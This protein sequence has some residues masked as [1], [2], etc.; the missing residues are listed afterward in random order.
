[1]VS[2]W[3][4]IELIPV[5]FLELIFKFRFSLAQYYHVW[6]STQKLTCSYLFFHLAWDEIIEEE[7]F[8]FQMLWRC[9]RRQKRKKDFGIQTFFVNEDNNWEL[10]IEN[11]RPYFFEKHP[12]NSRF[13]TV[14]YLGKSVQN[15][16]SFLGIVQKVVL[17]SLKV[18]HNFIL[19]TP[20]NSTSFLIGPCK[21]H[22]LFLWYLWKLPVLT[23]SSLSQS[24]YVL[25]K[26]T[27]ALKHMSSKNSAIITKI[28]LIL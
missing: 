15:K 27:I 13:I 24:E 17:F 9:C 8:L 2:I 14:Y 26:F 5:N 19:N 11:W 21:F 3:F 16:A 12:G 1:M 4:L 22:E 20:V 18:P 23:Y 28:N 6:V 10:E 25:H 7:V